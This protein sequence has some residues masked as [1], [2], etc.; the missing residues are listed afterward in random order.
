[1]QWAV[2]G[3]FIAFL[4]FAYII[5]QGTRAALAWRKAAAAGDVKVIRDIVEEALGAWRSMKRP[6]EVPADVWRGVQSMQFI[7]VGPE[8]VRVSCRAESE[9]KMFEGRWIEMKNPLQEGFAIGANAAEMLFYDLPHYR[10]DRIQVDVY[11]SFREGEG[12][13][14]N[15]CILSI[16]T[17]RDLARECDWD[18]WGPD[19]IVDHLGAR[20]RM[21][22]RGQPL[23]IEVAP[24]STPEEADAEGKTSEARAGK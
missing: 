1:M 8:F 12:P 7:D 18:E 3:I 19:A 5:I 21:G 17:T 13:T 4:V 22:E 20:Y 23:A 15:V 2:I 10:P 24:P 9:Y 14:T 6:K 16:E 11:T